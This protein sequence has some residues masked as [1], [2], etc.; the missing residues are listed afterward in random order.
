MML[1]IRAMNDLWAKIFFA[2]RGNGT[3]RRGSTELTEVQDAKRNA[4]KL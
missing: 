4:E 3:P 1:I 2:G